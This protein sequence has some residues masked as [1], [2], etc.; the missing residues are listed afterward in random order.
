MSLSGNRRPQA[1]SPLQPIK[2]ALLHVGCKVLTAEGHLTPPND[3]FLKVSG[4]L[5]R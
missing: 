2:K 4:E 1:A 3:A 5:R